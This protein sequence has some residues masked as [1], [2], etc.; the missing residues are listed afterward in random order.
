LGPPPGSYDAAMESL[1]AVVEAFNA[2]WNAH[3]LDAAL[4]LCTDDAVFESTDPAPDGRRIVGRAAVGEQWRPIFEQTHARFDIE[5]MFA[6]GD[7]VIQRWRYEWGDG[8]I[9]GVDIITVRDGC[10]AAKLSYVKG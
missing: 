1:L 7:R 2:A 10:V 5:E 8:H 9:R 6:A 4:E 3:D